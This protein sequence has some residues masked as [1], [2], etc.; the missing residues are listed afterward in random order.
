MIE[1]GVEGRR[2]MV[3]VGVKKSSTSMRSC[4]VFFVDGFL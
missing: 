1:I 4:T 3:D 2:D